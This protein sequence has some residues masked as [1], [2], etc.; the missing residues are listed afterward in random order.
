MLYCVI[1]MRLLLCTALPVR[2]HHHHHQHDISSSD[3]PPFEVRRSSP[4][5]RWCS[6]YTMCAMYCYAMHMEYASSKWW[7]GEARLG[8]P[9][10]QHP[11]VSAAA[12]TEGSSSSS[13]DTDTGE[14]TPHSMGC[15]TQNC[16]QLPPD[17]SHGACSTVRRETTCSSST[18]VRHCTGSMAWASQQAA[19]LVVTY[20]AIHTHTAST[21]YLPLAAPLRFFLRSPSMSSWISSARSALSAA[22]LLPST[23]YVPGVM[24]RPFGG[25][26]AFVRPPAVRWWW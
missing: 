26:P 3:T 14:R 20:T 2:C 23:V 11:K 8:Q 24:S 5:W 17:M 22:M 21:L 7:A 4:A 18:A 16:S 10:S 12:Q 6:A 13:G 25:Y 1:L 9:Q 15:M 19:P